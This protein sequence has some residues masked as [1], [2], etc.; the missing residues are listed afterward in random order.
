MRRHGRRAEPCK[1][2]APAGALRA[3][4]GVRRRGH[5]LERRQ[6]SIDEPQ[7]LVVAQMIVVSHR[8]LPSALAR[9]PK[10]RVSDFD[11]EPSEMPNALAMSRYDSPSE[12]R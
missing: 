8:H 11:T 12:R 1:Q 2:V 3:A 6:V 10:A 9:R 5:V 4:I 7:Q